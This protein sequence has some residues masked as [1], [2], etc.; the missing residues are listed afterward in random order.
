MLWVTG[1]HFTAET[2]P[3]MFMLLSGSAYVSSASCV[4]AAVEAQQRGI[5]GNALTQSWFP[6]HAVPNCQVHQVLKQLP[7]HRLTCVTVKI[8]VSF[9]KMLE[10]KTIQTIRGPLN[11]RS[12]PSLFQRLHAFIG[13]RLSCVACFF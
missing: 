12:A 7:K 6:R 8:L 5:P 4:S 9:T 10:P 13:L 11:A 3:M 2:C 1:Q